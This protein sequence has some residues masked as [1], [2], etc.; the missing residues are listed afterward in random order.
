VRSVSTPVVIWGREDSIGLGIAGAVFFLAV[1]FVCAVKPHLIQREALRLYRPP[2]AEPGSPHLPFL[3]G[4][5]YILMLRMI[6][7]VSLGVGLFLAA[8]LLGS[9]LVPGFAEFR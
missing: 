2:F 3:E 4:W 1:G 5:A 7:I 6:G 9:A 8:I